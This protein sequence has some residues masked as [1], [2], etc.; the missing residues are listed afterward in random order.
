[1]ATKTASKTTK[2]KKAT[3]A[4]KASKSDFAAKDVLLATLGFY[5]KVYEQSTDRISD[6][7][8]KRQEMFKEL[9]SRGEKLEGKA[10]DKYEE[11]KAEKVEAPIENLRTSLDKIKNRFNKKVKVEVEVDAVAA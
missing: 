5:G 1:M 9:V 6:M 11:L 3:K 10:K 4:T 8:E 7:N 2:A